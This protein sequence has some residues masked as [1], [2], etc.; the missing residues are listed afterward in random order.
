[1]FYTLF[2]CTYSLAHK[3][4][5]EQELF[6]LA[7]GVVDIFEQKSNGFEAL[8]KNLQKKLTVLKK[9]DSYAS[10]H[11]EEATLNQHIKDFKGTSKF[12]LT[13]GSEDFEYVE[14]FV[15]AQRTK[16]QDVLKYL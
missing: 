14:D 5:E 4:I 3:N 13:S 12:G 15:S 10:A 6:K 1:M 7:E 2:I 16:A 9:R 11:L 8:N